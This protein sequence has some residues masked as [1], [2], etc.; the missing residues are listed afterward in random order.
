[1]KGVGWTA[2][3]EGPAIRFENETGRGPGRGPGSAPQSPCAPNGFPDDGDSGGDFD[4]GGAGSTVGN[5]HLGRD[6]NVAAAERK[7]HAWGWHH[8]LAFE[9]GNRV[10]NEPMEGMASGGRDYDPAPGDVVD[11]PDG[12]GDASPVPVVDW[13]NC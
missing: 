5:E 7:S 8:Q 2:S 9:E 3:V 13:D 12:P 11:H 1:M 4:G 10:Q 6:G